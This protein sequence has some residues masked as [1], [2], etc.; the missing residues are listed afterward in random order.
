MAWPLIQA[1]V[2]DRTVFSHDKLVAIYLANYAHA[3]GTN[4][5]PSIATLSRDT[6][7]SRPT[8]TKCL[9][10]LVECGFLRVEQRSGQ[11]H[12]T[13]YTFMLGLP[14]TTKS[15]VAGSAQPTKSDRQPTKLRAPADKNL[16]TNQERTLFEKPHDND[17]SFHQPE[18]SDPMPASLREMKSNLSR[19][20]KP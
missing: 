9:A 12:A 18:Q 2:Q 10:R 20:R 16:V 17:S 5:Y 13:R 7:L 4:A 14:Q 11:H 8:V 19:I 3:D 15:L 6:G 1:V